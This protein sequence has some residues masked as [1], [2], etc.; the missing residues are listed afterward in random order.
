MNEEF[1]KVDAN[2]LN[3]T[4]ESFVGVC[5]KIYLNIFVMDKIKEN[6]H[7]HKILYKELHI[8][9]FDCEFYEYVT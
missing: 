2:T 7:H 9:C 3:T 1:I 6:V 4:K 8:I 5:I